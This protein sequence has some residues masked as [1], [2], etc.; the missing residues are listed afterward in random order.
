[1]K[2]WAATSCK[3]LITGIWTEMV[4]NEEKKACDININNVCSS[5][6]EKKTHWN[7]QYTEMKWVVQRGSST[8]SIWALN[9]SKHSSYAFSFCKTYCIYNNTFSSNANCKL[10]LYANIW[11]RCFVENCNFFCK[12]LVR[13]IDLL[14]STY[15]G[16]HKVKIIGI[17]ELKCEEMCSL[18][19]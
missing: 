1:M 15:G 2:T 7:C 5:I 4:Q 19:K 18:G 10:Q 6:S 17:C 12:S 14:S 11:I 13:N 9:L 8:D 3:Y 16:G